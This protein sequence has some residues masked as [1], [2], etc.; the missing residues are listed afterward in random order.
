[1]S[2]LT[3]THAQGAYDILLGSGLLNTVDWLS[4]FLS[5]ANQVVI[6]T[7]ET[8]AQ[9]Y[10]PSLT[11]KIDKFDVALD[12]IILTAG[13]SIKTRQ[14]K[15]DIEDK[16]LAKHYGRD[17]LMIALGGGVITDITGFV[18]ATYCRGIP[19][20][21][22]P[23][24]LLAMVDAAIGGKTAVNT[25]YG[26]N[27]IGCFKQP[28]LVVCD[29]DVMQTLPNNAIADGLSETLKHALIYNADYFVELTALLKTHSI[30]ALVKQVKFIA[31]LEKSCHVKCTIVQ[32]D[33]YERLG[34][35][36]ILN[37]GHT[38]AHAIECLS[39]YKVSHGQA[40]HAGLWV[41]S[42][43]ANL[44]GYLKD[45][46]FSLIDAVLSLLQFSHPLTLSKRD[47]PKL[48][49]NMTLDKKAVKKQARFVLLENIGKVL[50]QESQYSFTVDNDIVSQAISDW[51]SNVKN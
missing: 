40:V 19:V 31:A 3:L 18:A 8:V 34:E 25:P 35:R 44:L 23:T 16:M 45:Q 6:I 43:I 27:L 2:K 32:H 38:V 30:S 4:P 41:E 28:A 46:D 15:Q 5:T 9:L 42:R 21:Y 26:K 17:T 48:L 36:Q 50:Q 24:T 10:L 47:I 13:E 29:V 37:F 49:D 22:I 20:I 1:M 39:D 33:E 14:T 7:D 12:T 11:Q 51:I